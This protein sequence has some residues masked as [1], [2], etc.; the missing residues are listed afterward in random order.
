MPLFSSNVTRYFVFTAIFMGLMVKIFPLLFLIIDDFIRGGKWV[1]GKILASITKTP[2]VSTSPQD[3]LSRSDFLA[4]LG[5]Y[6]A[7]TP[8]CFDG[9]GN[10]FWST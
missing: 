3:S 6:L 8:N 5:S 1:Y 7:M 9:L 10:V 4:K 2:M